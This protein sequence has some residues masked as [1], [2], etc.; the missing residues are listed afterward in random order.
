MKK[1]TLNDLVHLTPLR[2]P[3]MNPPILTHADLPAFVPADASVPADTGVPIL[4]SFLRTVLYPTGT[5]KH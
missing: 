2:I 3:L 5:M 4:A 1:S